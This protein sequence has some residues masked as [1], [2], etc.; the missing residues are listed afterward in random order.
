MIILYDSFFDHLLKEENFECI[1]SI[2]SNHTLCL[3]LQTTT[4]Q[5]YSNFKRRKRCMS[6]KFQVLDVL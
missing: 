4:E 6:V 5:E 2:L 1:A 3:L